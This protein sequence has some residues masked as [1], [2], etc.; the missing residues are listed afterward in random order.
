M[1]EYTVRVDEYKT[2]WKNSSGKLHRTDGPA[3][4]KA[5][6]RKEWHLNGLR[7]REDGPAVIYKNGC[8]YWYQNDKLHREDGPAIVWPHRGNEWHIEGFPF[9]EFFNLFFPVQNFKRKY[10]RKRSK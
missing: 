6:G 1:I 2:E 3:I 5:Y 10:P 9:L 8:Q 4:I 7:H